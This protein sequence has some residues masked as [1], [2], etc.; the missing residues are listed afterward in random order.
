[1]A[2]QNKTAQCFPFASFHSRV[3]AYCD[4]FKLLHTF[5]RIGSRVG[6]EEDRLQMQKEEGKVPMQLK[7]KGTNEWRGI[8]FWFWSPI[9]SQKKNTIPTVYVKY[10]FERYVLP[11]FG[12]P[13]RLISFV[14]VVFSFFFG[15]CPGLTLPPV[16]NWPR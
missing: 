7:T 16:R 6:G 12:R 8:W 14:S 15:F 2:T 9:P 5:G 3:P 4:E 10:Q 11:A 13:M 1:M